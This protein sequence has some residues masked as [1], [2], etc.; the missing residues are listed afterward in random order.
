[1]KKFIIIFTLTI[2]HFSFADSPVSINAVLVPSD[3]A[4]FACS[5]GQ[6]L[7]RRGGVLADI[8]PSE[9]SCR[10]CAQGAYSSNNSDSMD[11]VKI[12]SDKI[13]SINKA[14]IEFDKVIRECRD[15]QTTMKNIKKVASL[16]TYERLQRVNHSL[17]LAYLNLQKAN[18]AGV[19]FHC[20]VTPTSAKNLSD[21]KR[22]IIS[23]K[24]KI[25]VQYSEFIKAADEAIS[26]GFCHN[27]EENDDY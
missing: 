11:Y 1:M 21:E 15:I 22:A 20:F 24:S 16:K 3:A 23:K 18:L 4:C 25:H 12:C 7:E 13:D 27:Y 5:T 17:A 9:E 6:P 19:Y 10:K 8:Y 2:S 14:Q 26:A